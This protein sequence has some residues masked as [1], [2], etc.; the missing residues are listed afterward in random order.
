M[1]QVLAVIPARY[2]STRLPGKPLVSLLGKPMIQWVYENTARVPEIDE[3]W[4]ATDDER[5]IKVVEGFGGRAH[6]TSSEH[7]SGTD[8]VAELAQR[9]GKFD[10]V[11]NVQGDEPALDSDEISAALKVVT[12]GKFPIGTLATP[13]L[14]P[15][16]LKSPAAV[17]VR[18]EDSGRALDFSRKPFLQDKIHWRHIGIYVYRFPT[19]LEFCRLPPSPREKAESLEQL[20]AVEKGIPIGVA[21]VQTE[22]RGVD[23]SDDVK[24]MNRILEGKRGALL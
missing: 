8:R 19:L 4:V 12:S 7:Q 20:R 11:I 10:V 6:L 23:T 18:L 14:D 5:I 24:K 3:T 13:L 9:F 21:Q 15:Q 16:E 2:A 1:S 17:K 22:A